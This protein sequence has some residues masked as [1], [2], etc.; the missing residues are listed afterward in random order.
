MGVSNKSF[1]E[2]SNYYYQRRRKY[3]KEWYW[4]IPEKIKYFIIM[5]SASLFIVAIFLLVGLFR[6]GSY[7]LSFTAIAVWIMLGYSASK[8]AFWMPEI[9]TDELK[10]KAEHSYRSFFTGELKYSV[11]DSSIDF[12]KTTIASNYLVTVLYWMISPACFFLLRLCFPVA[13]IILAFV[14]FK[15]LSFFSEAFELLVISATWPVPFLYSL[16]HSRI[17]DLKARAI[18]NVTTFKKMAKMRRTNNRFKDI[19]FDIDWH[20]KAK[21]DVEM[22]VLWL[23]IILAELLVIRFA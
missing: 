19:E 18:E 10:Y 21:F 16:I 12:F 22:C 14:M 1:P 15:H 4:Y 2:A 11:E 8:D 20:F 7:A 17:K 6:E 13:P 9:V 23:S 5:V 3:F